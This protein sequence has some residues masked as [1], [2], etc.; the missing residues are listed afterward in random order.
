MKLMKVLIIL[1]LTSIMCPVFARGVGADAHEVRQVHFA[2]RVIMNELVRALSPMS[3]KARE[4]CTSACPETGALE[5]GIGLIGISRSN[6][7]ANALINLLGLQLD[8]AG[9]E[10]LSCQILNRGTALL[11]GL[12]KLNVG[13]I[14]DQC[15]TSFLQAR[16]RELSDILDV[17]IERVC[18]SEVEIRRTRDEL[19]DA[20]KAKAKCELE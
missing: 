19:I 20:I 17:Q 4:K 2:E 8:G 18:R 1:I 15:Q 10:E 11:P 16:K 5:L 3:Q 9:S 12:E 6:L 14:K 13:H 7:G